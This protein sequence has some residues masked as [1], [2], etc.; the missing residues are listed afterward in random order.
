V[1]IGISSSGEFRDV[2]GVFREVGDSVPTIG[3]VHVPGSSVARLAK[4]VVVSAGGPSTVPVMTKTF[5]STVTAATMLVAALL[6]RDLGTVSTDID[7]ASSAAEAA[8]AASLPVV[9]PLAGALA[10]IEHLFVVGDGLAYPA[11]LEA[12]LKLK[13][14]ALVHAEASET[15]EMMSGPSTI[16]GPGSAVIVLAPAGP[17]RSATVAMA[18]HCRDWGATIALEVATERAVADST[19]VGL[20]PALDDS[21]APLFT[22]PPVAL[23]AYALA[24][25][26]G[27]DPDQPDWVA[28]YHEQGLQHILG[29]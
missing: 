7:Q 6:G 18:R 24:R 8:I 11:A 3:V 21:F 17:G 14:M 13:E 9:T 10:A 22:V 5:S 16:V 2:V 12:A 19:F 28:R 27:L 1:L 23:F 4:Y 26:R 20:P 25:A 15:W 29:A